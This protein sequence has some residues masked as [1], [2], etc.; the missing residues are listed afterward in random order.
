MFYPISIKINQ[1]EDKLQIEIEKGTIAEFVN[2]RS[3]CSCGFMFKFPLVHRE[4]I[5][6]T[7]ISHYQTNFSGSHKVCFDLPMV[8]GSAQVILA[9]QEFEGSIIELQHIF[10]YSLFNY[11]KFFNINKQYDY[12][13]DYSKL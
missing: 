5:I 11:T 2:V 6:F 4:G 3:I 8:N 10:E 1:I 13:C 12:T 7:Y 9:L